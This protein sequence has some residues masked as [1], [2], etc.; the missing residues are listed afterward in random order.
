MTCPGLVLVLIQVSTISLQVMCRHLAVWKETAS[1]ACLYLVDSG[2]LNIL[3]KD[4]STAA[5]TAHMCSSA[6]V[7]LDFHER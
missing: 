5:R 3:L 4:P 2:S 6:H 1:V 7:H